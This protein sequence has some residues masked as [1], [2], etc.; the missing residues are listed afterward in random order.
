MSN[1]RTMARR[2]ATQALYQWQL[3]G[4]NL[5]EIEA[6]FLEELAMARDLFRR[7]RAGQL[8]A[9]AEQETLEELLEK[10]CRARPEE[11]DPLPESASLEELAARCCPPDIH[12]GYFKELLHSVPRRVDEIDAAIGEFS[13]RAMAELDPVERAVLRIGGYELL[14]K[15]DVPYRVAVN[16]AINLAKQFGASESHKYVNGLLDKLAR[17]HRPHEASRRA[18]R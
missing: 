17:K 12:E 2:C 16:E 1:P 11:D 10:Y 6:Q 18:G 13:E 4:T 14:F 15:P 8:T 9:M 7:F 5:M 3:S